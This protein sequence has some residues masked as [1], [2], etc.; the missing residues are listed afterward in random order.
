MHPRRRSGE[1][2]LFG[3]RSKNLQLISMPIISRKNDYD[4]NN[5]LD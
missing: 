1:V 3:E 2:Q 5:L 4:H